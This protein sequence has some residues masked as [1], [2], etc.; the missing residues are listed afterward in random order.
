MGL[1]SQR[2]VH[3]LE[4][5]K[6]VMDG[7]LDQGQAAQLLGLSTRQVKRLCRSIRERGPQ[8]LISRK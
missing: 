7:G 3:R 8:G 5:I 1:M 6:R 4:V 2:E